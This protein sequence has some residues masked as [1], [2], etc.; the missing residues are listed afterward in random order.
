[1]PARAFGSPLGGQVIKQDA[2]GFFVAIEEEGGGCFASTKN[3]TPFVRDSPLTTPCLAYTITTMFEHKGQPLL[4]FPAFLLRMARFTVIGLA[5]VLGSLFLGML[6]YHLT[7][8]LSW[9]DSFLNAAMLL[10]GM[11]PID[12]LH[13]V[14]G[15]VFAGCYA[16]FSGM[17]FLI[18]VGV[19]L[20]PL[21][22]RVLH[23]FHLE[24]G[25]VDGG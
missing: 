5:I 13:T 10:G 14:A 11:G 4:P 7:E 15:K 6:G 23:R 2:D 22:H 19:I 16:L 25:D 18:A 20:T 17:I 8:R 12:P 21:L 1:L 24:F 3:T 9:L